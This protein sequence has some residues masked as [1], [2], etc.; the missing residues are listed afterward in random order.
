M[1]SPAPARVPTVRKGDQIRV[2]IGARKDGDRGIVEHWRYADVLSQEEDGRVNAIVR[3]REGDERLLGGAAR[4]GH[5]EVAHAR[6]VTGH[7]VAGEGSLNLVWRT[8]AEEASANVSE[9]FHGAPPPPPPVT[10]PSVPAP[11]PP[12]PPP[13][14]P[15]APAPK[16]PPPPPAR[17]G[18][19]AVRPPPPAVLR[20]P[21]PAKAPPAAATAPAAPAAP[22]PPPPEAPEAPAEAGAGDPPADPS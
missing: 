16:P 13:A 6:H 3:T 5:Y 7:R 11:K 21:P 15:G 8:L 4:S 9:G 22:P 12:P 2:C 10:P 17:P 18:A 1:T 20:V 19:P 14:R